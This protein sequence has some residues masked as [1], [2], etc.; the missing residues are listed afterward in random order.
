MSDNY[1]MLETKG[2]V[3]RRTREVLRYPLYATA[4][5]FL[6]VACTDDSNSTRTP[7]AQELSTTT[8]DEGGM[9]PEDLESALEGLSPE[10]EDRLRCLFFEALGDLSPE[11]VARGD[12]YPIAMGVKHYSYV[13]NE[14]GVW[15]T[16][17]ITNPLV[18]NCTLEEGSTIKTLAT[19]EVIGGDSGILSLTG[20]SAFIFSENGDVGSLDP[21]SSIVLSADD[22][23]Q[24]DVWGPDGQIKLEY[25]GEETPLTLVQISEGESS[26]GDSGFT[27]LEG[28]PVMHLEFVANK[29]PQELTQ[30]L[31]A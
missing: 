26:P 30:D 22:N 2:N 31:A 25:L 23:A 10:G 28:V 21:S 29:T 17:I 15:G 6:L 4:A 24:D 12:S 19:G 5:A 11:G 3:L 8:T 7:E 13:Q 1:C 20:V 9:T 14:Q 27:T 16:Q 18:N